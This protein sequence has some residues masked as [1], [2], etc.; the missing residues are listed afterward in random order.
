MRAHRLPSS[1]ILLLLALYLVSLVLS[2]AWSVRL[3]RLHCQVCAA[4][5]ALKLYQVCGLPRLRPFSLDALKE[6][7][8]TALVSSELHYF[9]VATL[10]MTQ[11]PVLTVMLSP[12]TLALFHFAAHAKRTFGDTPRWRSLVEP[13]YAQL[14][15]QQVGS[16]EWG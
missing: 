2:R 3:F 5:H 1:Q 10:F 9:L 16:E 13:H 7:A 12:S 4:A 15:A 11:Q 6:W 8:A 14:M